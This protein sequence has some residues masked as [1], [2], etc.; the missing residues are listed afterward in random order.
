M[1]SGIVTADR[2]ALIHL[3]VRGPTGQEQEIEAIIDTG[4]DGCLSLPSSVIVSLDLPWRERGR[5]LLADGSESVFDIY[6]STVLWD[7]Q[8]RRIP[9][10]EAETI[11]LIGMS[12]LQGHELTVQVQPGGNVAIR[13]LSQVKGG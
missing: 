7:G 10:H 5:A 1:I 4:F 8:A 6:E 12:L 2:Q 9:V 3:T 11:P 13:R